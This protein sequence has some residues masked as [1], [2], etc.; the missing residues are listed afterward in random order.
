MQSPKS[1]PFRLRRKTELFE[2]GEM[3]FP[4]FKLFF[5]IANKMLIFS[6]KSSPP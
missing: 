5:K 3:Y 4:V 6:A 1:S 2:L